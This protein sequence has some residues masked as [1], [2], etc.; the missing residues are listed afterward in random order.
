MPAP[1]PTRAELE[2]RISQLRKALDAAVAAE[3]YEHAAKLRDE[4]ARLAAL[5]GG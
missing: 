1:G 4:L 5:M 2:A 3:R